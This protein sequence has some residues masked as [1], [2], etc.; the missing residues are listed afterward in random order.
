MKRIVVIISILVLFPSCKN[1]TNTHIAALAWYDSIPFGTIQ[2]ALE[3]SAPGETIKRIDS[4]VQTGS[5]Y[6]I[7]FVTDKGSRIYQTKANFTT[8]AIKG[9]KADGSNSCVGA[10]TS[11]NSTVNYCHD[12]ACTIVIDSAKLDRTI[13]PYP[14]LHPENE[15]PDS[16]PP[17]HPG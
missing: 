10:Y 15:R 7:Y 4:L 11:D 12:S 6:I 16:C 8:L 3:A 5:D 14:V 9:Y 13:R 2:P 1:K 17:L